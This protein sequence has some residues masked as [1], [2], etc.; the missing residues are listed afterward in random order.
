[1]MVNMVQQ[2]IKASTTSNMT[3]GNRF[4]VAKVIII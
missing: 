3:T 2:A 1:M 4:M